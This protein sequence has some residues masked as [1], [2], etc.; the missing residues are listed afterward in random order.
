MGRLERLTLAVIALALVLLGLGLLAYENWIL[1]VGAMC[2][3]WGNNITIYLS[4]NKQT[5]KG[6]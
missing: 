2:L 3:V 5:E 6:K 1:G 4:K